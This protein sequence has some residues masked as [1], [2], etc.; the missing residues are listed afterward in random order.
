MHSL[1]NNARHP[2]FPSRAAQQRGQGA[3]SKS[4]RGAQQGRQW[5]PS[6]TLSGKTAASG[7]GVVRTVPAPAAS[8]PACPHALA[9]RLFV[10]RVLTW[11]TLCARAAERGQLALEQGHVCVLNATAL[12]TEVI[13][14]L[15]LPGVGQFTL[16]DNQRVSGVPRR[17]RRAPR[18]AP[19][20]ARQGG[21]APLTDPDD[22]AHRS[23]APRAF[24]QSGISA[25]T[26]SS[27]RR[28]SGSRAPRW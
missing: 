3:Q 15:V 27:R 22:R 11:A 16:V 21:R 12:A 8:P 2:F 7:C 1:K 4:S 9:C 26:S 13:K 6:P 23:G 18:G 17:L 24:E 25:S 14:N 28:A 10:P 5:R 19:L 20:A